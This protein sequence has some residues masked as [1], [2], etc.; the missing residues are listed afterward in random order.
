[1]IDN[2]TYENLLAA[3]QADP[4]GADFHA[5]RMAFAQSE[6]YQPYVQHSEGV[7]ALRAA[8]Q[9][10]N[11]QA[12][13]EACESLLAFNPL[14]IEAHMA[15]DYVYTALEKTEQSAYHRAFAKGLIG[16]IMATGTGR[17]FESA[18]IV[19]ATSEEYGVL[20]MMGLASDRQR[21]V[22]H[23]GHWF[24]VLSAR[25]SQG[26]PVEVYFN[27]DLPYTWLQARHNDAGHADGDRAG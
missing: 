6:A 14:D 3:T 8:L 16:A 15:A 7:F 10:Q 4:V 12:A 2:L 1:M 11:M 5:L 9:A 25:P 26:D 18:I 23:H 17:D 22:E 19:L 21:L 27:I 13:L 24:D 20:R